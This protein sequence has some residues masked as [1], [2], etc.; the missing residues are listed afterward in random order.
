MPLEQSTADA[1]VR[2]ASSLAEA[3]APVS[4]L[5]FL[6]SHFA[7]AGGGLE[8]DSLNLS[9]DL[10]GQVLVFSDTKSAG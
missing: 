5:K 2:W 6:A 9:K 3:V 10:G 1:G 7:L 8:Q 4:P